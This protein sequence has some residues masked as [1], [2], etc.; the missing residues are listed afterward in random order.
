MSFWNTFDVFP[1][2]S[3]EEETKMSSKHDEMMKKQLKASSDPIPTHSVELPRQ[4]P[5][6]TSDFDVKRAKISSRFKKYQETIDNFRKTL[7]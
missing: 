7:Q 3:S 4:N 6:L 1:Y 5:L 2:T